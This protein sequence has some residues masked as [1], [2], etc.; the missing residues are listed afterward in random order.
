MKRFIVP[1]R[2]CVF[3]GGLLFLLLG[4]RPLHAH[5]GGEI[6]IAKEPVG[7]YKLTV[8][9]NPPQPQAGKTMHITVA[10]LAEDDSPILD[11]AVFL[12][13]VNHDTG[14][15][16]I[17]KPATTEQSTNKLFY[18][19]DFPAPETGAY[20]INIQLTKA[21]INGQ[22]TFSTE[23]QPA[24]NTNWLVVGFVS[25]GVVL[26]IALFLGGRSVNLDISESGNQ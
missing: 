26:A 17:A 6:K 5:G 14:Q 13:M 11:A 2:V 20:D 24:K 9:L 8:W 18:E 22:V 16:I 1:W 4:I 12:E 19:T 3:V 25:I 10:V 7:P 15:A 23:V 21:D